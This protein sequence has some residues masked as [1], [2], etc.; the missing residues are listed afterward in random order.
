M[1]TQAVVVA[2]DPVYLSW[3]EN[4]A[5][6]NAEFSLIRPL[7]AEDLIERVQMMGRI[8]VVFFQFERVNLDA[9]LVMMER[10]VERAPDIAVAGLG[11]DSNPDVV[12]AA[13]RAGAR[14]FFVL[15]RDEADVAALLS[16]LLRRSQIVPRPQQRQ[17]HL[18]S[19][20]AAQ[21]LDAIA[22]VAGHLA[23]ACVEQLPKNEPTLLIDIA[24]PPGA[25]AVFFNISQ[26]YSVLDA[27]NDVYR[28]DQTLIDTAFSRHASGLYLLSLP[29]D[30]IGR[31]QF[32][33]DDFV[34]LLQVVRG[35]FGCVVLAFDAHWPVDCIS[36]VLEQSERALLLSD[37]SIIKSR[38]SKYLLRALRLDDCPLERTSLLVDGYRK[39]IGLEPE[40][41]AEILDLPLFGRL[42]SSTNHGRIQAMNAGEPVFSIAPKEPF[43]ADIR[44]LATAL[45]GNQTQMDVNKSGLARLFG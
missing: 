13:M 3:L 4:A 23:L 39:R 18:Y 11:A 24:T 33:F 26:S 5:G 42:S 22:F 17:G 19:M 30:L 25:A 7:D 2:D 38:H 12:L 1:K 43:C 8:D 34:K 10:L 16:K 45:L 14:D 37:Q 36:S 41:L 28:C 31:P 6:S 35:L 40:N 32:V 27:V 9:R 15:R 44:A 21:P 20:F 29:E